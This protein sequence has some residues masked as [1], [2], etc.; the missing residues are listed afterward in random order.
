V[1]ALPGYDSRLAIAASKS[2]RSSA[3][4]VSTSP[5]LAGDVMPALWWVQT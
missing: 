1:I 2:R 5:R 3:R 4:S